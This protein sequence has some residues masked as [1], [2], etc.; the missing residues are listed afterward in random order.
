MSS[1][2]SSNSSHRSLVSQGSSRG[3]ICPDDYGPEWNLNKIY[4]REN[5]SKIIQDHLDK[6]STGTLVLKGMTGSGKSA[7]IE[8]QHFDEDGW[9]FATGKYEGHRKQEPYSALIDALDYIVDEWIKNNQLSEVCKM[10]AFTNLLDEDLELL[11]NILPKA[12]RVVK[13]CKLRGA[14]KRIEQASP[15]TRF[16]AKSDAGAVNAAFWRILSFLC[17]QKPV[18]LFLDDI[19]WADQ[20]SLDAI[21]VLAT[22]GN[23]EGFW[24]VLSYRE[25]EVNEGDCVFRCL[26]FIEEEGE[27]VKTIQITNLDVENT[28]VIVSSLLEQDPE[29]TIELSK[30]IYSKTAG[31]PFFVVQFM[32][33]LRHECFLK[34]TRMTFEWEWGDIDNMDQ[35]ASVSDNVADV[36]AATMSRLPVPC[37]LALKM[38][39]C[40][41][42]VIPMYILVE[43]LGSCACN[44]AETEEMICDALKGIRLK[45]LKQVLDN[46]VKFGI[47][48]RLSD[49]DSDTYMWVHDKLQL[50][51]YSMIPAHYLQKVHTS[52]GMLLWKMHKLNPENEWMLYMAADQLN[53]LSDVCDEGLCEDIARLSFEAGKL[54]VSKSAFFPALDMIRFAAKHLENMIDPW[55]RAYNLSLEIYS[56]LSEMAIRFG[57]YEEALTA[58]IR[59]DRHAK[60]LEDKIRAQ[61]VVIRHKVEGNDRDYLGGVESIK[62]ILLDYGVK[63]PKKLIPGQQFVENRKLKSRLG[64]SFEAFLTLP[65]LKD[66]DNDGKRTRSII[67]LLAYLVEYTWFS[68]ELKDLNFYAITRILNISIKQGTCCETALAIGGFAG[69]LS[70]GGHLEDGMKCGEIAIKLVDAF[71]SKVGSCHADVHGWVTFGVLTVSLP[72]HNI[73]DPYLELNRVGLRSGAIPQAA[74]AWI[75]YSYAY[76]C[77]GLPLGPLDSDLSSFA[78]EGR[79]FGMPTT[80]KVLFPISRQTIQ[81]LQ[82]LQSNPT[83]LKGDIFDQEKELKKFKDT[84]LK[85]TLRDINSF[86]LMLACIYQEWETAEELIGELEQNLYSDKM[87]VRKHIYLVY[88]GYASLVLG[89]KASRFNHFR[90]LGKKIIKIFKDRLKNGSKDALPIIFMLEAIESPSKGRFDEAIRHTARLGLIQHAAVIYENAGLFFLNRDQEGWAEYYLSEA[91]KLYNEWGATGKAHQM[92][93]KYGFLN[94][95]L[96]NQRSSGGYIKGRK[97][98]TREDLSQMKEMNLPSGRLSSGTMNRTSDASAFSSTRITPSPSNWSSTDEKEQ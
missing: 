97:R 36:I 74:M 60:I 4:G 83:L 84:G 47:L 9:V 55:G 41:G 12:F 28:N 37:L 77:V 86:R 32:Q 20:A 23:I 67:R 70:R 16:E 15:D 98:F 48:T 80:L 21:Q 90:Q 1:S 72:F 82:V 88:M 56:S 52:L 73:L 24:L 46:A 2:S 51:A 76:L 71:P 54:S 92:I 89:E 6:L 8:S 14:G 7:L 38:A 50:V 26:N 78:K 93:D 62:N 61:F 29:R 40:L 91:C 79:Q 39:S 34:Y 64:G 45:G 22:T 57:S 63:F 58:A 13:P 87:L 59:V 35:L 85:M 17:E 44:N 68:N 5:E 31:N 49:S 10:G 75:A 30:V 27:C 95:S 18:V 94:S 43:Y 42:K 25:E 65:R 66:E 19:Q 81:N 3:S 33:M 53:R 96:L 69:Y 11:A